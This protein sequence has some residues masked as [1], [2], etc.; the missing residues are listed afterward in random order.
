MY[1]RTITFDA[2]P[3][4][5]DAGLGYA[6]DEVAPAVTRMPGCV[7]MSLLGN[8]TD[9]KCISAS[10][11]ES[12]QAMR[13]S[14]EASASMRQ[15]AGELFDAAPRAEEWEM[16]AM[17]RV[18][19][20]GAGA[21]A[22]VTWIRADPGD[23]DHD[24]DVFRT[25][26]LPAVGEFGGFCSGSLLVDRVSGRSAATFVYA[27]AD[28]LAETRRMADDLRKRTMSQMRAALQDVHEFDLVVAHLHAPE[29]V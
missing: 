18:R 28:A 11:W 29:L 19:T 1:A 15:R 21:C 7:G 3:E 20:P 27:D 5:V 13:E 16:A 2:R 23:V 26:T 9:G 8:R 22:R 12:E 25:I 4:N 17:H 24:I 14:G 6:R 10:A